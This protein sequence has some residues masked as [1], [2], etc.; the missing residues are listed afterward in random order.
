MTHHR[1]GRHAGEIAR[2]LSELVPATV[3]GDA[4]LREMARMVRVQWN[5][6]GRNGEL[7][8][9]LQRQGALLREAQEARAAL[10]L[11]VV[12]AERRAAEAEARALRAQRH[13]YAMA[14]GVDPPADDASPT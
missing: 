10:E 8:R 7:E 6:D 4:P 1:A 12:D 14:A 3:P 9:Q 5:T 11:R 13:A 2:L